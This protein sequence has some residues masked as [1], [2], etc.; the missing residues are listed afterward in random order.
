MVAV[1]APIFILGI[2][3]WTFTTLPERYAGIIPL[4][5]AVHLLLGF[6]TLSLCHWD[7]FFILA[8]ILRLYSLHRLTL[9]EEVGA[10]SERVVLNEVKF[11]A[12]RIVRNLSPVSDLRSLAAF[13]IVLL[14]R[15]KSQSP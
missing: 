14:R 4:L 12:N 5:I 6:S 13:P 11:E 10:V 8:T 1:C 3:A 9:T 15:P 2:F 7:F